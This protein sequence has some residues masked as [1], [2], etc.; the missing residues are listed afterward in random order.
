MSF[1]LTFKVHDVRS[2]LRS[3]FEL[4]CNNFKNYFWNQTSNYCNSIISSRFVQSEEES[5]RIVPYRQL[6]TEASTICCYLNWFQCK[7]LISNIE[8]VL[9]C[10]HLLGVVL[11]IN[12]CCAKNRYYSNLYTK[13]FIKPTGN[14]KNQCFVYNKWYS[15][16]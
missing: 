9:W 8:F 7:C 2:L 5:Y 4:L 10:L 16:R 13:V 15:S 11:H 14:A 12:S 3:V 1:N 6:W